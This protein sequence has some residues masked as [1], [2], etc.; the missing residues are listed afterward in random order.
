MSPLLHSAALA[1]AL[2]LV[3]AG[4][5]HA[6]D[7]AAQSGLFSRLAGPGE[8]VVFKTDK[9]PEGKDSGVRLIGAPGGGFAGMEAV[10]AITL[11]SPS[12]NLE[13]LRLV[14]REEDP[15]LRAFERV[16]IRQPGVDATSASLEY[17]MDT[18]SAV[19]IGEPDVR[20]TTDA[21]RTHFAGMETFVIDQQESG[22]FE[23]NLSGPRPITIDI[24]PVGPVEAPADGAPSAGGFAGLGNTVFIQVLPRGDVQPVVNSRTTDTGDI[25]HFSAIGSI[26][27]KSESFDLRCDE[28]LFDGEKQLVEA[29]YNVYLKKGGIDA[30]CGRMLYDLNTGRITLT[31]NPDVRQKS[32]SGA[33][34]VWDVDYFAIDQLA[35]GTT[36]VDYGS[37][38]GQTKSEFINVEPTP[39]PEKTPAPGSEPVEIE[40]Q[41]PRVVPRR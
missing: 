27:L 1:A 34:R 14:F 11:E 18:G 22:G 9:H 28:L 3:C 17:N 16:A 33:L 30:D 13:C 38:D 5:L 37:S 35:D 19:L 23:V 36:N 21:N 2:S 15:V 8:K 6:N 32:G 20:Q 10:G 29:L 4:S 24:K 31:V 41:N 26:R 12:L 25:A 40:L 39:E 7:A